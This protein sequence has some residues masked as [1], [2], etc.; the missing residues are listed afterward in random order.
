[1]FNI[2]QDLDAIEKAKEQQEAIGAIDEEW[3]RR[4]SGV[5]VSSRAMMNKVSFLFHIF[6]MTVINHH[7]HI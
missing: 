7:R 4:E 5:Q 2:H 6:V 3:I 1:M